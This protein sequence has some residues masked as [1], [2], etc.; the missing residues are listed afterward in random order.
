MRAAVDG[1]NFIKIA[2]ISNKGSLHSVSIYH[3]GFLVVILIFLSII[4]LLGINDK[5]FT[6]RGVIFTDGIPCFTTVVIIP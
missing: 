2:Q 5:Q 1:R 3:K 6:C 4:L